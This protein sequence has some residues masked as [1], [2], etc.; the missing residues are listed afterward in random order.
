MDRRAAYDFAGAQ[1]AFV[2][3]VARCPDYAEGYNQRA[4]VAF[5]RQD[6]APALADIGRAL[7]LDPAHL[8]ALIGKALVLMQMGRIDEGQAVLREA[9]A[10]HPW[11]PERHMLLA[12]K[13]DDL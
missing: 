10:L 8:G 3:L 2:A 1:R 5:L 6:F 7:G 13:G 9:V 11:S 4:F 12:P